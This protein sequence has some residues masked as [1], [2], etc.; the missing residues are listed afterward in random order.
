MYST[1]AYSTSI[2]ARVPYICTVQA[3]SKLP[4][5]ST[6][7]VHDADRELRAFG[8]YPIGIATDAHNVD[9]MLLLGPSRMAF[10]GFPTRSSILPSPPPPLL[11]S[12]RDIERGF[13][14]TIIHQNIVLFFVTGILPANALRTKLSSLL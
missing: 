13:L 8:G 4:R 6:V 2:D 1:T 9:V 12:L 10:S 7:T 5:I 3:V 14:Q 11:P